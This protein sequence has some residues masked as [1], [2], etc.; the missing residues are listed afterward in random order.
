MLLGMG[1]PT[2]KGRWPLRRADRQWARLSRPLAVALVAAACSAGTPTEIP[3]ETTRPVPTIPPVEVSDWVLV[4]TIGPPE[5]TFVTPNH[6]ALDRAGNLYVTE[7][8]GG[9]VLVF[10]REFSLVTEWAGPGLEVGQLEQPTGIGVRDDG[11]V[12]VGEAGGNRVQVFAPDGTTTAVW[13]KFGV[14]PGEFGSAMGIGIHEDLGRVYVA[15][16]VNSRIHVYD[17][18]GELLFMFP[19]DGD[20]TQIGSEP[21]QMWLPGG[22]DIAADGSVLVVDTGN[23]RVQRWSP[24]GELVAVYGTGLINDPQVISA[25]EDGSYWL[26]GPSDNRVGLFDADGQLLVELPPPDG[27]FDRPHGTEM[28]DDGVVFVAD[29]FNQVVHVYRLDATLAGVVRGDG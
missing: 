21:D 28:R 17:F 22:V 1:A 2:W 11:A 3:T 19:N 7:F 16:H 10:D 15:D 25:N 6:L 23:R 14:D 24:D 12:I 26:A 20:F 4:D 8:A 27:G 18:D 13:G 9:R 29:T 5:V